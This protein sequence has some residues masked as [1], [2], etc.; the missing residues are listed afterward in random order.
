MHP[1]HHFDKSPLKTI[2]TKDQQRFA[3][4]HSMLLLTRQIKKYYLDR[5]QNLGYYFLPTQL[6]FIDPL[7]PHSQLRRFCHLLLHLVL[8]IQMAQVDN[9]L[10]QAPHHEEVMSRVDRVK[11]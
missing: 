4:Q 5:H 9:L 8:K 10:L 1:C 6:Q 11:N 3:M 7:A 2:H